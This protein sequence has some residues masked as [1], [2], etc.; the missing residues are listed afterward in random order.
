MALFSNKK[1]VK[2]AKEAAGAMQYAG[3][4]GMEAVDAARAQATAAEL[5]KLGIFQMLGQ[6]AGSMTGQWMPPGFDV[7]DTTSNLAQP[8]TQLKQ[9]TSY[10]TGASSTVWDPETKTNKPTG[11]LNTPRTGIVDPAKYGAA[12]A[13]SPMFQIQSKLTADAAA[14]LDS[15]GA[16]YQ[17]ITN[18][19]FGRINEDTAIGMRDALR[20][21]ATMYAKTPAGSRGGTSA[22]NVALKE[23]RDLRIIEEA[24]RQRANETWQAAEKL[25][26]DVRNNA[27]K[28]V[29][30]N[31]DFIK[32][33]PLI[34][35]SFMTATAKYAEMA[36]SAGQV[37]A[38]LINKGY[39]VK[40]SQKAVNFGETLLEGLVEMAVSPI[41]GGGMPGMGGGG[42][43]GGG[44]IPGLGS[45]GAGQGKDVD[46][47]A[48]YL[49]SLFGAEPTQG[50]MPAGS[51]AADTA[52]FQYGGLQGAA[53]RGASAIGSGASA[54]W[55]G[56]TGL[57]K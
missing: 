50:P 28:M 17:K 21:N 9:S 20:A 53:D 45:V 43:M 10:S 3:A 18:S 4:Y 7:F 19:I 35:E 31:L 55:G 48:N 15:S 13:N 39:L 38:D 29:Q 23:A 49:Q 34:G 33:L 32:Q 51:S 16:E 37:Q 24:G 54:A 40:Q 8:N 12:M 57:F 36:V 25:F 1:G 27:S 44:L 2:E 6:P 30:S 14:L 41:M 46:A 56:I 5:T 52:Q 26:W 22:R 11:L 42:G 47:G